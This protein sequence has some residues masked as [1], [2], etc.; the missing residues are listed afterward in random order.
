MLGRRRLHDLLAGPAGEL[1][2][3]G[4]D[5]PMLRGDHIEP[6]GRLFPDHMHRRPAARAARVFWRDRLV[7]ARQMLR[8]RAAVGL[9]P[10]ARRVR[11][12][13]LLGRLAPRN[14]LLDVFQ[15]QL[16]LVGRKL[17]Q[18]LAPGIEA[19]RLAQ[20]LAKPVVQGDQPVAFGYG[21]IALGD[22]IQGEGAQ[23]FGVVGNGIA[24]VAHDSK[25]ST[26]RAICC[27]QSRS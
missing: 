11:G 5:D 15:R 25:H 2:A 14:R 27:A 6:L 9:A 1:G 10:C 4:D 20:Q 23:R 17:R 16:E 13:L 22:R 8:Q 26:S 12:L 18:P 21:R 19:L 3:M 24:V 7:D